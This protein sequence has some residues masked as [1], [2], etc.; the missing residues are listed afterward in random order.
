MFIPIGDDNSA[1][2]SYPII[3]VMLI[4]TTS[5]VWFLQLRFGEP[6]T[7]ALSVVPYEVTRNEDLTGPVQL[8]MDGQQLEIAHY[9]SAVPLILTLITSMFLHGGW[10]HLIGNMLYLWIFGDQI[11]DRLGHVKYFVF[12]IF[13][14]IFG[15][16]AHVLADPGSVI[17]MVGASGA[18]SGVLGAYLISFPANRITMWAFIT[19]VRIPAFLVIGFWFISQLSGL[20]STQSDGIA[21]MAHIGGFAAG[22]L[23]VRLLHKPQTM[24]IT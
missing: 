5:V 9:P 1:R 6:F 14:G 21:Y 18:I 4:V 24:R 15:A 8:P 16:L 22:I 12:Y 19:T 2:R 13:S 10:L 11:E 7:Y 17:H 3:N 23:F 20:V